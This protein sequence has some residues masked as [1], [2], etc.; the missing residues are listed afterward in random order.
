MSFQ[1]TR[2]ILWSVMLG[3]CSLQFAV[4]QQVRA[5]QTA[6]AGTLVLKKAVRRVVVD[7][8]VTDSAGNPVRGLTEKDFSLKEDGQPQNILSFDVHNWAA[9]YAPPKLPQL[10]PN[11]YLD[12]PA[13]PERGPLYVLLYDLVNTEMD[14]QATAR[15]E[16][17]DFIGKKPEGTRFA[18]FVLTDELR[19]VQGFTTIGRNYWTRW[20]RTRRSL[21]FR[22]FFLWAGTPD[23][24]M[25]G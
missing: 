22:E 25:S 3:A 20:I 18:I 16:L 4:A 7:V 8:V 11:T 19:L 12:L 15:K 9:A 24:A 13:T 5:S 10:P 14:D 23:G 17:L 2:R 1:I 6:P 21:V